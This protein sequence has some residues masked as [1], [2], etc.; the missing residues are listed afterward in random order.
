MR[1]PSWNKSQAIQQVIMLK[2]LL[3]PVP[4]CG[5]VSRKLSNA[6]RKHQTLTSPV[7]KVTSA[8]TEVSVSADDSVPGQRDDA[9]QSDVAR[10]DDFVSPSGCLI[11]PSS[12]FT[13]IRITGMTDE[14][15]G[16]MT[17]FYS[18]KVNVYDEVPAEKAWTLLQLA[19]SPLQFPQEAPFNGTGPPTCHLQAPCLRASTGSSAMILPTLQTAEGSA[20]RKASVHRYLEKRKDSFVKLALKTISSPIDYRPAMVQVGSYWIV[21]LQLA[22]RKWRYDATFLTC[23]IMHDMPPSKIPSCILSC[24][25]R[26]L[27]LHT[28]YL[29][30]NN[31]NKN[32]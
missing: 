6:H 19:A 26:F 17:I 25:E 11:W 30:F 29:H 23:D 2:A 31:E 14:E 7:Q 13:V 9:D 10:D 1:K 16:Q 21:S 27:G 5:D 18:G 22:Y 12:P 3:E 20:S 4:E 24:C 8:D 32:E 15:K 28:M